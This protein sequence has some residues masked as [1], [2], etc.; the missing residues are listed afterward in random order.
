MLRTVG[1]LNVTQSNPEFLA[2]LQR[3]TA[4]AMI[5]PSALRNAGAP[6]VVHCAQDFLAALPLRDLMGPT[7]ER[8]LAWLDD[9]TERLR[10]NFPEGARKW[11]PA[12][13]AVNIFMR[14]A[15]YT[16]PLAN[17]YELVPL[18]PFLEVPLDKDVATA[19]GK[20]P[21]GAKLPAWVSVVSLTTERSQIY[22]GTA[23]RVARRLN[24]HCADLDVF[25]WSVRAS[26]AR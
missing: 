24:V 18:L 1:E 15:A 6:G 14:T 5:T 13:K 8:Y 19:L 11:G 26:S 23:A 10:T 16:A 25:Y 12:R 17:A 22:Q 20:T 3:F 21:E 9:Q 4:S 7:G 2:Q